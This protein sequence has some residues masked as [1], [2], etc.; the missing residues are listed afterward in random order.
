MKENTYYHLTTKKNAQSILKDGLQP[1]KGKNSLAV[2]E[3]RDGVFLCSR[4]DI[5]KWA[6]L[7]GLDTLLCV[8]GNALDQG[9][10][11]SYSYSCYD[12]WIYGDTI[13]ASAIMQ[14]L[15][16][17]RSEDDMSQLAMS[18]FR[19]V[20]QL[21]VDSVKFY[22]RIL[23][24]SGGDVSEAEAVYG[25]ELKSVLACAGRI[26]FRSVPQRLYRAKLIERGENGEFMMTDWYKSTG[27]RLY[28]LLAD[29]SRH[30]VFPQEED[31]V[32]ALIMSKWTKRT[33]S[34]NTGGWT[35]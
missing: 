20:N 4:Q 25:A 28:E 6:I 30:R 33:R 8:D 21:V 14:V 7:L 15:M 29:E 35:G 9:N 11:T 17:E 16:P 13:P 19:L 1:E 31:A 27:M 3:Q 18:I 26:D 10:L 32:Y 2:A 34:V 23:P 5:G 12:E 24:S 22:D